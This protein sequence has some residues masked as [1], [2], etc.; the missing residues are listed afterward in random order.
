MQKL[1]QAEALQKLNGG[2]EVKKASAKEAR[3]LEIKKGKFEQKRLRREWILIKLE[4]EKSSQFREFERKEEERRKEEFEIMKQKE[5]LLLKD[6]SSECCSDDSQFAKNSQDFLMQ[7]DNCYTIRMVKALT[8]AS[9]ADFELL[10]AI[11]SLENV[12]YN[13]KSTLPYREFVSAICSARLK[14]KAELEI[15]AVEKR[16]LS[17]KLCAESERTNDHV[18]IL[19]NQVMKYEKEKILVCIN[20]ITIS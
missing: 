14:V 18:S 1:L 2:P 10:V 20:Y 8:A 12:K 3:R 9:I 15:T 17:N 7:V 5:A 16:E 6:S 4:D 19:T 13:L 11:Q